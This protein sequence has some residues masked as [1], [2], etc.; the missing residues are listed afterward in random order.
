MALHPPHQ[1]RPELTDVKR[2]LAVG[3]LGPAPGR[4]AEDVDA[5]ATEEIG[6]DGTELLS[7]GLADP[8][9]QVEVPGGAAGHRDGK[10]GCRTD[11][12]TARAIGEGEPRDAESLD[13]SGGK[14]PLV[15][16]AAPQ[17][18]QAGPEGEIPVQ[19][20]QLLLR[21][22][23]RHNGGR[24]HGEWSSRRG[25]KPTPR[26]SCWL[27][28]GMTRTYCR[29]AADSFRTATG[30]PDTTDEC[31][32]RRRR[33]PHSIWCYLP[34]CGAPHVS[35]TVTVRWCSYCGGPDVSWTVTVCVWP[36]LSV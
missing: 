30:L 17:V 4:M 27:W 23:L 28:S 14:G 22:H 25:W 16:A 5:D 32:A 7:D 2:I 31:G 11:D 26:H 21:R 34:I 35:W 1:R 24:R 36:E 10:A 19:A 3:L 20:P 29:L 15:V 18:A 9:F 6:T 13:P 33:T 12:D 8:L